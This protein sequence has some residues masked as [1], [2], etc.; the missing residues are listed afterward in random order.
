MGPGCMIPVIGRWHVVDPLAEK[1]RRWSPYTYAF[2]NPIRFID[3]DGRSPKEKDPV[4]A[5]FT[6]D[7][8]SKKG[9]DEVRQSKST[10]ETVKDEDGNV[11]KEI[12]TTV[13]HSATI[14]ADGKVSKVNSTV[15]VNDSSTD[16]T[17][18]R[19]AT[20]EESKTSSE[21][22]KAVKG[23]SDY[24]K[25]HGISPIQQMAKNNEKLSNA[26]TNTS[27]AVGIAGIPLAFVEMFSVPGWVAGTVG[28]LLPI[29]IDNQY[30]SDPEKIYFQTN[31]E[32][33]VTPRSGGPMGS[34]RGY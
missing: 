15:K 30:P 20:K 18:T 32:P 4:I 28:T 26:V 9:T 2:D 29:Y 22:N 14:S 3:P 24:K 13:T 19:S 23:I 11:I 6:Y 16:K 10:T 8:D 5:R 27:T 12:K 34:A 17:T 31:K 25:E 21:F 7:K 33:V 1:M